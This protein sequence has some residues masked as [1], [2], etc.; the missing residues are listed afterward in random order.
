MFP[1]I[2]K[3]YFYNNHINIPNFFLRKTQP[4]CQTT[5]FGLFT[6][7]GLI[8]KRS[9]I[10]PQASINFSYDSIFRDTFFEAQDFK[11]SFKFEVVWAIFPTII[12]ISILIPSLY[13][14]YSLDEDLDPKLT[15]K[16]IGHHDIGHMNLIIELNWIQQVTN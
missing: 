5:S 6:I 2:S 3:A 4:F 15:I 11:H 14:L 8:S 16:V 12:I 1:Y 9:V 10:I 7:I 13:L